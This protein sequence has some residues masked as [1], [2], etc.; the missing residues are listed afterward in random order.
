MI[1]NAVQRLD[2]DEEYPSRIVAALVNGAA[3]L[4]VGMPAVRHWP[5]IDA[6]MCAALAHAIRRTVEAT[7][8]TERAEQR[9]ERR[10]RAAL[11]SQHRVAPDDLLTRAAT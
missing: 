6:G 10:P 8:P 3:A 5:D 11:C 4:L 7:R 1:V 2:V 9:M